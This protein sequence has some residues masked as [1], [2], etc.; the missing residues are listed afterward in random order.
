MNKINGVDFSQVADAAIKA[1]RDAAR[2]DQA[3][4]TLG[5]IV[6]NIADN[7]RSDVELIA[8]QKSKGNFTEDDAR[9]YMEDQKMV[10]RLRIR[11]VAIIGLQLAENIWNAIARVFGSAVNQALGWKVL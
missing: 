2:N 1:A 7:L 5:D 6:K 10:A 3:W 4:D 8:K 9:I 11:S